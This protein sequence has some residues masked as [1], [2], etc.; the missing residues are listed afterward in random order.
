[1]FS[2]QKIQVQSDQKCANILLT[3][4]QKIFSNKNTSAEAPG[5]GWHLERSRF[6]R[7]HI[8]SIE[9]TFNSCSGP[10]VTY[11][12][13]HSFL[14]WDR[15]P[16]LLFLNL[17]QWSLM[18]ASFKTMHLYSS[19]VVLKKITPFSLILFLFTS[20]MSLWKQH[21]WHPLWSLLTLTLLM[22]HCS[23]ILCTIGPLWD[24]I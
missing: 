12:Y 1:M 11:Q 8:W 16:L 2:Y 5:P 9:P 3:L 17:L 23:L 15:R 20:V 22:S 7:V 19:W 4:K 21:S 10:M 24:L 13:Y 6:P 14:V 18:W